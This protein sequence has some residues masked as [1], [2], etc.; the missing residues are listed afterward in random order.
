MTYRTDV[1]LPDGPAT[2]PTFAATGEVTSEEVARLAAALGISGA[3]RLTGEQWLA[4]EAADGAGPRLTVT[5]TAP[6]TWNFARFQAGDGNGAGNGSGGD[7]CKRGQDTCGP[8][9]LPGVPA[10]PRSPCRSRRP[11]PP[12]P[13]S[14]RAR[15]RP[16]P[17][18]TPA[19]PRARSG[20]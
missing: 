11:S 15:A 20:W 16:T 6:G 13:R 9:T 14:S 17:R 1:K 3:P 12:P 5:R 8:A 18:W 4:G 10:T 2:A 19:S 7:N